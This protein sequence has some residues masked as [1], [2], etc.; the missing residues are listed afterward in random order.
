MMMM[1]QGMNG[2]S[3]SRT[4]L[5]ARDQIMISLAWTGMAAAVMEREDRQI[6]G[7]ISAC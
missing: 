2:R 1:I 6:A 4:Y 5:R 7:Y 3:R